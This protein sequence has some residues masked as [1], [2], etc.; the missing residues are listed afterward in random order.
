[1]HCPSG[2]PCIPCFHNRQ[3]SPPA[4]AHS[5][6]QAFRSSWSADPRVSQ[7]KFDIH[8]FE[9]DFYINHIKTKLSVT[10]EHT[11]LKAQQEPHCFW[12]LTPVT[13]P[14]S[15]QSTVM[16]KSV[17]LGSQRK[18]EPWRGNEALKAPKQPREI[19]RL[20][21]SL[22]WWNG[23]VSVKYKVQQ[24]AFKTMWEAATLLL[25]CAYHV[26]KFSHAQ[27]VRLYSLVGQD[28]MHKHQPA[29]FKPDL[30]A[31]SFLWWRAVGPSCK[32]EQ[33]WMIDP[34]ISLLTCRPR[35]WMRNW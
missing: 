12:S 3:S 17:G 31:M 34:T 29:I 30:H 16:G 10:D 21:S 2:L 14:F 20:Y 7:S 32:A 24:I 27:T 23:R 1:M 13:Y 5:E 15:L 22:S 18:E 19:R 26:S 8:W 9:T 33:L 4:V 6:T 11:A 28:V 25:S 35:F